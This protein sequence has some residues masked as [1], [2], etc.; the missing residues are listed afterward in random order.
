MSPLLTCFRL[1][2][3]F[4]SPIGVLQTQHCGLETHLSYSC[5]RTIQ[6]DNDALILTKG[7]Q[8][9]RDSMDLPCSLPPTHIWSRCTHW[10]GASKI[11]TQLFLVLPPSPLPAPHTSVTQ[12]WSLHMAVFLKGSSRLGCFLNNEQNKRWGAP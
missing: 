3:Y 10:E 12:F 1:P 4:S 11:N 6:S 9:S 2:C 5:S 8:Q 7:V